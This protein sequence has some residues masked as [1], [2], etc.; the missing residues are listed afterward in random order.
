MFDLRKFWLGT[1]VY[2]LISTAVVTGVGTAFYAFV[3]MP[4]KAF[5]QVAS[6]PGPSQVVSHV[7]PAQIESEVAAPAALPPPPLPPKVVSQPGPSRF[8]GGEAVP[9]QMESELAAP[10]APAPLSLRR[11]VPAS[12]A[13]VAMPQLFVPAP[14]IVPE[15]RSIRRRGQ[16]F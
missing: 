2:L 14:L 5:Q 8:V 15:R 11:P 12:D 6:Q 10:A 1:T 7:V 9:A 4:T 16:D 3:G 13:A